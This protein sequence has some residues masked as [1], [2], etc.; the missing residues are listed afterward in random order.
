MRHIFDIYPI[1]GEINITREKLLN[2]CFCFTIEPSTT[3]DIEIMLD[4]IDPFISSTAWG[5][6][7]YD[8]ESGYLDYFKTKE[9]LKNELIN[10][11]IH[12]L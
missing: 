4:I 7:L 1:K 12:K 10:S 2:C 3:Y 8:R 6:Y 11:L 5:Y 9:S